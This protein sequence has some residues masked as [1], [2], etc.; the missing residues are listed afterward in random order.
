M[1]RKETNVRANNLYIMV[2]IY[3]RSILLTFNTKV[4]KE[5]KG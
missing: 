5:I 1:A 4:Y 2:S 3:K